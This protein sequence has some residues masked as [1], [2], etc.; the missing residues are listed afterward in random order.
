MDE[1]D[2]SLL[3]RSRGPTTL[4]CQWPRHPTV[5]VTIGEG[6]RKMMMMVIEERRRRRW[7]RWRRRRSQKGHPPLLAILRINT[8]HRGLMFFLGRFSVWTSFVSSEFFV[9]LSI[10]W[11]EET[12]WMPLSPLL[13]LRVSIRKVY[14]SQRQAGF[15]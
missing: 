15:G 6:T 10:L 5:I 12:R 8:V 7:R 4:K 3:G 11:R 2:Q 9:S 13:F 14:K 1:D